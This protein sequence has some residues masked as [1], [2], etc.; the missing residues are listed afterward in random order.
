MS[1]AALAEETQRT[2]S[3]KE[4]IK[5]FFAG[6]AGGVAAVLVGH[7]FDLTKTRLQTAAPGTYTGAVDVVKKA[8]A[9]DGVKGLYRG[10]VPPLLGVTP[11]FAV[12][13]WAYDTSKLLI[14]R[15]TPNRVNKE[16][17]IPE[18][19]AAGF[20]SAVPTT[21]IT[22]PVE[23][24]KVLLQVQGQTP[25]GPQYKGVT[26]VVKHLYREGG[27]RSVFRGSFATVARDGPGSAA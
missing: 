21:L 2:S 17:S 14:L 9:V 4:S 26:D 19:A 3:T 22:A 16:L 6:G 7:P 20:F 1:D 8:L 27:L 24:A 15:L 23:R 5:S 13:F 18:L 10:V 25:N 12:S 11:I